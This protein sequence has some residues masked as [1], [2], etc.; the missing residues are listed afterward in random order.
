MPPTS[1][2]GRC[3]GF[4]LPNIDDGLSWGD[5]L[6][7][8]TLN[9]WKGGLSKRC[10][11]THRTIVA[12]LGFNQFCNVNC[13]TIGIA[14]INVRE[15]RHV[16]ARAGV[17]EYWIINLAAS[18]IEVYRDLLGTGHDADYATEL[19]LTSPDTLAL[20]LPGTD[21]RAFRVADLVP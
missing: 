19:I 7:T 4:P 3:V 21:S 8:T 20:T 11:R 12:S 15:K 5:S 10:Q 18:Q 17:L 13:H 1:R 9:C 6:K 16:Y 2:Y 14:A